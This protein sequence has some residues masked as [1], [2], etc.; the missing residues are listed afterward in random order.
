LQGLILLGM[1]QIRQ[2]GCGACVLDYVSVMLPLKLAPTAGSN[3]VVGAL[4]DFILTDGR[5]W[6][7]RRAQCHGFLGAA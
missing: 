4:A 6:E 1:R 7:F 2:Q 5:R 3:F